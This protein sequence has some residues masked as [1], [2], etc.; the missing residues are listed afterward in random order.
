MLDSA[1]SHI[2]IVHMDKWLDAT[3]SQPLSATLGIDNNGVQLEAAHENEL[4][5][6]DLVVTAMIINTKFRN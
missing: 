4:R 1:I 6:A 2:V 5:L 3:D